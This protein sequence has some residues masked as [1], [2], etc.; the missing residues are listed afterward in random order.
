M[1]ASLLHFD[2]DANVADDCNA[3]EPRWRPQKDRRTAAGEATRALLR[4]RAGG[5]TPPLHG[6]SSPPADVVA[7]TRAEDA[8]KHL[9]ETLSACFH[10]APVRTRAADPV[11]S[12]TEDSLLED[13]E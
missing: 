7:W 1:A 10:N 11:S 2:D 12:I 6:L 13:D 8:L 4:G 9:D 3:S 5:G